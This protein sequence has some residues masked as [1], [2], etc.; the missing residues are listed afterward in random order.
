MFH[1]FERILAEYEDRFQRSRDTASHDT[2]D[3][4]EFIG[5]V[6][7]HIPD[8]CQVMVRHP[9]LYAKAHRGR[10]RKSVAV[11]PE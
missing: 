9:G 10:M 3:Y 8:K 4:L 6:P 1:H 2:M 7:L 5:R 11:P